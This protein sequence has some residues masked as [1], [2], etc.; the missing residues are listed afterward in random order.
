MEHCLPSFSEGGESLV[1]FFLELKQAK[2]LFDPWKVN[3]LKRLKNLF[4]RKALA[5][6]HLNISFGWLPFL[7]DL[8]RMR[9]SL[10]NFQKK[11]AKF[12][13]QAGKPQ[14][15]HYK[16]YVDLAILPPDATLYSDA[17]TVL[18]RKALW[19]QKPVYH[20]TVKFVFTLPDMG[21]IQNQIAGFLDSLGFQLNPR[22]VWDSIPYSFLV[23][24]F[25]DVGSWLGSLRV[26]NLKVPAVV[27]GF[28]H[29]LKW[30]WQAR[31]VFDTSIPE[32]GQSSDRDF[33]VA[34]RRALRYERRRDIPSWGRL[35]S[36]V[37][38]PSWKQFALGMSLLSQNVGRR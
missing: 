34:T 7:S 25:V 28:C 21:V 3:K 13:E 10:A 30:E 12:Q 18:K 20:A 37:R 4:S 22:I 33:C 11:L 26:D 17:S 29:S 36:T 9:G 24:W 32:P 16:R 35:N 27:T 19:L 31:Y 14:T 5:D 15:R 1:N 23:D 6:K 2:G 38:V 8:D